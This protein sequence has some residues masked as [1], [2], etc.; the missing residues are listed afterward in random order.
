[1]QDSG[2]GISQHDQAHIFDAFVQVGKP[3]TQKGTGLGLSIVREF[4][5]LMKGTIVVESA[6][7]VGS[8][9]RLE[10]P[11]QRA[12]QAD[13]VSAE[14]G[15]RPVT[16]IAPGQPDYRVL[17][18]EDQEENW[19]LLQ[20]LLQD[21]GFSV[22]LA[23]D[24]AQG[25]ELFQS[26]R[27]H[28][29]W[30]DRRM[31][32]MDGLEATRRIRALEGGKVVKIAAVTASTFADQRAEML[33]AGM[34]DFVRKPYRSEEIFNCM[35]RQLGVRFTHGQV[36]QTTPEALLSAASLAQLSETMRRELADNLILGNVEHLA[37][38]LPRI[39]QQ[40]A[41]LAKA[42]EQHISAFNFLPILNLL[43]AMDASKERKT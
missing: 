23:Q 33:A 34:D 2:I 6:P 43:E 36:G 38:L 40:D 8:L 41:T 3:A 14:P 24:G 31:P 1:V 11:V 30:M 13:A 16:G 28:F 39:A 9:F 42:L 12:K 29:I 20:R 21:A 18:V 5:K 37:G 17:I 27:P 7:D 4:V 35:E 19:L 25:V 15:H 26:Y 10:I 32:V 22:M